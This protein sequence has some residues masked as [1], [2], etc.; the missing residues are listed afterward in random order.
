MERRPNQRSALNL[1]SAI[2]NLQ[3]TSSYTP[4]P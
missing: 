3:S 2:I 4:W 1:Q